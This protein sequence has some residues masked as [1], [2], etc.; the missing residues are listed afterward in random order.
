MMF[1]KK[2]LSLRGLFVLVAIVYLSSQVSAWRANAIAERDR[3]QNFPILVSPS[4]QPAKG[5]AVVVKITNVSG[6]RARVRLSLFNDTESQKAPVDMIEFP[7]LKAKATVTHLYTPPQGTLVVN[8]TAFEAP[9]GVRVL[10]QPAQSLDDPEAIRKVVASVHLVT[11]KAAVP[12]GPAASVDSSSM[13]PLERCLYKSRGM[14]PYDPGFRGERYVWD[15]A[16]TL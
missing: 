8:G 4:L 3:S 2:A 16:P 14:V 12:N 15:C 9:A 1:V 7:D 13:V 5:Q 10:I 6:S 11:L